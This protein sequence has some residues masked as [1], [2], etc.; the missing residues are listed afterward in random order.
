MDSLKVVMTSPR[1]GTLAGQF[2]N[3]ARQ[4]SPVF[5]QH[6][7]AAATKTNLTADWRRYARIINHAKAPSRKD[8]DSGS[9]VSPL[10]DSRLFL[11][12]RASAQSAV[13][14]HKLLQETTE[15]T[16]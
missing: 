16:E 3:I 10:H 1:R 5:K 14:P 12:P 13:L 11:Y 4:Y 7:P 2:S 15:K 6:L 9:V 8:L